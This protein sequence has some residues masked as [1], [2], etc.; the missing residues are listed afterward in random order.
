MGIC[1]WFRVT[2]W[3]Y[4]WIRMIY[5]PP[6]IL[7]SDERKESRSRRREHYK[8]IDELDGVTQP[9]HLY[10]SPPLLSSRS[11][12]VTPPSRGSSPKRPPT[13]TTASPPDESNGGRPKTSRGTRNPSP[14]KMASY[15]VMSPTSDLPERGRGE[16][17]YFGGGGLTGRGGGGGGKEEEEEGKRRLKFF[18]FEE[19]VESSVEG[20]MVRGDSFDWGGGGGEDIRKSDNIFFDNEDYGESST[21]SGP[22]GGGGGGEDYEGGGMGGVEGLEDVYAEQGRLLLRIALGI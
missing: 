10:D 2:L 5:T 15:V 6:A 1:Y 22:G 8:R 17:M 4:G 9:S 3:A 21:S 14:D 20:G 18:D 12:S 13:P 19:D 16:V 7:N 11:N